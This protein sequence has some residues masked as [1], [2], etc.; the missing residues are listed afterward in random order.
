MVSDRQVRRLMKML[1]RSKNLIIAAACAGMDEKTARKYRGLGKLPS[2]V[3]VEHSWRTRPDPFVAVW[4]EVKKKL[5]NNPGLEA[6]TL[7]AYLQR[8]YP[9]RYSDGQV[10]T[11]RYLHRPGEVNR[12]HES[13]Q[14]HPDEIIPLS[15]IGLW[16]KPLETF[17]QVAFFSSVSCDL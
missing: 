11:L 1:Q 12:R 7:F 14:N 9:G 4:E 10:R 17:V 3:K 2:E 15:Q 8:E 6:M 16:P 5:E 13:H